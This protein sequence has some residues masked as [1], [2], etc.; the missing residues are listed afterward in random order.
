MKEKEISETL[1]ELAK[2]AEE[3]R[4]DDDTFALK[5][6]AIKLVLENEMEH[7]RNNG[8]KMSPVAVNT[9]ARIFDKFSA[10]LLERGVPAEI[11]ERYNELANSVRKINDRVDG[12]G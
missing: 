2:S 4:M 9:F 7:V 11:C 8:G 10:E 6:R 1:E 3:W 12:V 5:V